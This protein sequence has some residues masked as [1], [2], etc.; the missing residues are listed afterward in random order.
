M[1]RYLTFLQPGK[2]DLLNDSIKEAVKEASEKGYLI[3][4]SIKEKSYDFVI[5]SAHDETT[6]FQKAKGKLIVVISYI[7]HIDSKEWPSFYVNICMADVIAG[8]SYVKKALSSITYPEKR[9]IN[10]DGCTPS[11]LKSIE[12][13][14]IPI[15]LPLL[16]LD[17]NKDI[18]SKFTEHLIKYHNKK[19]QI[20]L[21][22]PKHA[23]GIAF[24]PM[25]NVLATFM[26]HKLRHI[27]VEYNEF[28]SVY[29][30]ARC[31]H[32]IS[33]AI[34]SLIHVQGGGTAQKIRETFDVFLDELSVLL[35]H[36]KKHELFK[37][38]SNVTIYNRI[39]NEIN[40][41]E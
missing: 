15:K 18:W 35:D 13:S 41:S 3:D 4:S 28:S 9:F 23:I 19:Y 36:S 38:T 31:N 10:L 14:D 25:G 5:A 30:D 34:G 37:F 27:M 26:S 2:I 29:L 7:P 32:R 1:Q 33:K 17:A 11:K 21:D 39:F 16:S 40:R 24:Y 22:M 6:L 8:D 20:V 12:V